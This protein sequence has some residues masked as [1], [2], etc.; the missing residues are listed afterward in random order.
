[1]M[2]AIENPESALHASCVTLG[3]AGA[4]LLTRAQSEGK[5]RQDIDGAELFALRAAPAWIREQPG[6]AARANWDQDRRGIRGTPWLAIPA[7]GVALR[8]ATTPM[9][10]NQPHYFIM[11]IDHS[12]CEYC[13]FEITIG[14]PD[15]TC[16]RCFHQVFHQERH[17]MNV[18]TLAAQSTDKNVASAESR[19]SIWH[20][21]FNAWVRSHD[22]RVSPDGKV[23]FLDL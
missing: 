3:T 11:R 5:A 23:F 19:P 21:M 20:R 6:A 10:S 14:Q 22:A 12:Q 1:M 17:T 16:V 18:T 13:I 15:R 2:D 8:Q 7:I 9:P 4:C